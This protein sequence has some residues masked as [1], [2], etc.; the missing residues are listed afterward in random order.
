MESLGVLKSK[1]HASPAKKRFPFK[2]IHQ[3]KVVQ[4]NEHKTASS[5]TMLSKKVAMNY[6]S[7]ARNKKKKKNRTTILQF[8]LFCTVFFFLTQLR[9]TTR[10]HMWM[11][12]TA[13]G[14]DC[15]LAMRQPPIE[16]KRN[17]KNKEEI[18]L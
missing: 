10:L 1:A 16:E 2:P 9:E 15:R 11:S 8:E 5:V 13:Y 12:R 18:T 7:S 3:R 6:C 17:N 14:A 4:V